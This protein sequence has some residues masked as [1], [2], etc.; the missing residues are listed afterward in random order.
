MENTANNSR[1]I[2][3]L[4]AGLP[5][6]MILAATWLWYFVARGELDIVGALGTANNG[7][8]V[9]PPRALDEAALLRASGEMLDPASLKRHWTFVVPNTGATCDTGCEHLLYLT[10]QIHLAMGKEYNRIRRL[11][12]GN[13][14]VAATELAVDALSDDRPLPPGFA[15]FLEKEHRDL[16]PLQAGEDAL[17]RLFPEYLAAPDTW[18]L[19]DPEGWVMMSYNDSVGYKDVI[20]DLKFLLKNS[21]D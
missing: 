19:V 8:L 6:T 16:L 3:L 15:A 7:T 11:Y 4:I 13:S 20:A 17:H 1:L 10:R 18:Y 12:I 9:E 5:V 21:S 2:L 14:P